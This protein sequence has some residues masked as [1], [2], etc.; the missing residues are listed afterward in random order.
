MH[1][2]YLSGAHRDQKRASDPLDLKLQMVVSHPMWIMRTGPKA[3]CW[4]AASAL[5][6]LQMW[7]F[8]FS[9]KMMDLSFPL[10]GYLCAANAY[11]YLK[12]IFIWRES[13][14]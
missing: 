9:F 13:K 5:H 11:G 7:L 6:Q 4:R 1:A 3:L 12:S 2:L 8:N 14:D 10:I